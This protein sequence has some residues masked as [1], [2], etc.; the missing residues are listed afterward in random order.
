VAG[1]FNPGTTELVLYDNKDQDRRATLAVMSHEAFHQYCYF[2]FDRSEAHRWFDEGHGD[3]YGC[4]EFKGRKATPTAHMPGG[5]DRY[6]GAKTLV[7]E[8]KYKP[9]FVHINYNHPQWQSQGPNNTSC[10]EQSWSIIHMLRMGALGKVSKKVWRDEYGDIIPNYIKVLHDGYQAAYAEQ[11]AELEA[12]LEKLPKSD[13][14]AELR[15]AIET[16]LKRPRVGEERKLEIWKAA[17]DASWGQVDIEQFEEH[18]VEF[19]SDHL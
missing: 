13:K 4:Y 12:E 8:N 14:T 10:Y 6:Q 1:Y 18:W 15:L 17:M 7:R 2:L 5:L 19:V 9:I 11:R 16:Q 3:F